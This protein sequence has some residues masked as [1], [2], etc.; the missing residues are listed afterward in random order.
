MPILHK[1]GSPSSYRGC[2]CHY[3]CLAP[4]TWWSIFLTSTRS[5]FSFEFESRKSQIH[6]AEINPLFGL[7]KKFNS[8]HTTEPLNLL[9]VV[10]LTTI[11]TSY[12]MYV[13]RRI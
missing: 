8:W 13:L 9:T 12:E 3:R 7:N 1:S 11:I 10:F 4:R 6:S 5:S 2:D